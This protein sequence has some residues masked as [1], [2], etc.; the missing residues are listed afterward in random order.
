MEVV[1]MFAYP[2]LESVISMSRLPAGNSGDGLTDHGWR[3]D[4]GGSDWKAASRAVML[5]VFHRLEDRALSMADCAEIWDAAVGAR[6]YA[7]ILQVAM[8]EVRS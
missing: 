8:R 3:S 2:T 4:L 1:V 6:W 5:R 7:G